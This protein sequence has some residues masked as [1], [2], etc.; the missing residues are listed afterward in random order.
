MIGMT[1]TVNCTGGRLWR[2]G[3]WFCLPHPLPYHAV[4]LRKIWIVVLLFDWY[5]IYC[6]SWSRLKFYE[7]KVTSSENLAIR[8]Y[9]ACVPGPLKFWG[10]KPQ[11][12][13]MG[14]VRGELEREGC[15]LI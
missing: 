11:Y 2:P 14:K 6:P 10:C 7:N 15:S 9:A 3:I 8:D 4:W 5:L 12:E 13:E 1:V